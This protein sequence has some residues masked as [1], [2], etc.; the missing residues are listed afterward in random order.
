MVEGRKVDPSF[1]GDMHCTT[2][3]VAT[4][5]RVLNGCRAVAVSLLCALMMLAATGC[6][7]RGE[8][9]ESMPSS[10]LGQARATA[11]EGEI[12]AVG[13]TGPVPAACGVSYAHDWFEGGRQG[14]GTERSAQSLR[15]LAELGVTAISLTNFGY[16]ESLTSTE[17][18][19]MERRGGSERREAMRTDM[20][21]AH[22]LN[23]VV[24]VKPHIWVSG[25]AWHGQLNPVDW[26]ALYDSYGTFMLDN[27][28]LA[29]EGRAEYFVVGTELVSAVRARPD[30]MRALIAQVREVYDGQVVYAANWDEA[31]SVQIWDAVDVIGVQMYAPLAAAPEASQAQ[32]V[33]QARSWLQRYEALAVHHG[34]PLF[35]TEVGFV[36]R[37]GG[38]VDPHVWPEHVQAAADLA[39]DEEQARAVSA[40]IEVFGASPHVGRMFWWKWYTNPAT[41]D[42]GVVGFALRGKPALGHL[43]TACTLSNAHG[44]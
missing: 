12:G 37:V 38:A 40:I 31:E 4:G 17:V 33:E 24:M 7:R 44:L 5:R 18:F 27:A 29:Q 35:L 3:L 39:G 1:E 32:M 15:E 6:I 22:A 19:D 21:R 14:Y 36:N 9:A 8:G 11:T 26:D 30:R 41:R 28:R 34:K 43:Q 23:M 13:V 10:A 2:A 25:G 16:M 20:E 42:E